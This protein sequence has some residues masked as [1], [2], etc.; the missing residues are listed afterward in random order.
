[1]IIQDAKIGLRESKSKVI[2]EDH[3]FVLMM[4]VP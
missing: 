3:L 4:A 2:V 1:M